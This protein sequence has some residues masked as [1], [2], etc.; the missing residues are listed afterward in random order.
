MKKT[1]FIIWG[2]YERRFV[3]VYVQ[4]SK[5]LCVKRGLKIKR[6][7]FL[8]SSNFLYYFL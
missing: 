5:T 1:K 7:L 4:H 2:E 8:F 6:P 3:H